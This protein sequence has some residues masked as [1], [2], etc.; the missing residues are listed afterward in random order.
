MIYFAPTPDK[1][2][3]QGDLIDECPVVSIVDYHPSQLNTEKVE[4]E[5]RRVLVPVF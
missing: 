3:D 2:I 4:F 5:Q 1:F